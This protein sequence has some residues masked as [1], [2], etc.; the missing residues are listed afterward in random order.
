MRV[1]ATEIS[2]F[3]NLDVPV[4]VKIPFLV[5]LHDFIV[6]YDIRGMVLGHHVVGYRSGSRS[7]LVLQ[8]LCA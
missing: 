1:D 5:V 6:I 4:L 7:G 8:F 3:V 2:V